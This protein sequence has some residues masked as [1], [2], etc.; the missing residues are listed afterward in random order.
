MNQLGHTGTSSPQTLSKQRK[1]RAWV[2]KKTKKPRGTHLCHHEV[3][4]L[5]RLNASNRC[6]GEVTQLLQRWKKTL[7]DEPHQS[8]HKEL[9]H[10]E[11]GLKNM[12]LNGGLLVLV[13][14]LVYY[15]HSTSTHHSWCNNPK[16]EGWRIMC[17]IWRGGDGL[18]SD[19]KWI[20]T[21]I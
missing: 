6:W 16:R 10:K 7:E 3:C 19:C 18:L 20:I 9:Q 21:S 2:A 1:L 13:Y 5:M 14:V 11:L 15:H 17:L 4:H 8:H 12:Q